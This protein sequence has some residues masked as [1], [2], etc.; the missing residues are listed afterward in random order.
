MCTVLFDRPLGLLCK[1]RDKDR[2]TTEEFVHL[3]EALAIKTEGASYYSL[4]VNAA[5]C[6]FASTAVNT[7]RWIN[8]VERG[9]SEE[10][11]NIFEEENVGLQ[12]PSEVI[13]ELLP[14]VRSVDVWVE[15]LRKADMAWMGY[16][17]ILVDPEK[18]LRIE[19]YGHNMQ[20][21]PLSDKDVITNHFTL[22]GYGPQGPEEYA[23]S[24]ERLAYARECVGDAKTRDDIFGI[25]NPGD[26][27]MQR[28]IWRDGQFRTVSSAVI[29]LTEGA[30]YYTSGLNEAY[31][32]K[33]IG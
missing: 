24:Y 11:R 27:E 32:K 20:E 4:G 22:L 2:P 33:T 25:L 1:N 17:L 16:N 13:S 18:A 6:A 5:G 3:D 9:A 19:T 12:R 30:I 29:D 14:R 31:R 21:H 7:P 28:R 23:N 10:A 8:A 26:I 15:A